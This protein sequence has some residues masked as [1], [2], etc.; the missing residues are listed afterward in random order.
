MTVGTVGSEGAAA[1]NGAC[2]ALAATWGADLGGHGLTCNSI[3]L[4]L[5]AGGK[6]ASAE[7][8]RTQAECLVGPAVMLVGPAGAGVNGAVLPVHARR[9]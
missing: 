3:N 9:V 6:P 1:L 5:E 4:K 7:G 2:N 8:R